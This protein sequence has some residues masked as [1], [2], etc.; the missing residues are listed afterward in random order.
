MAIVVLRDL[1]YAPSVEKPPIRQYTLF[2]KTPVHFY[3]SLIF[4]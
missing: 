3:K 2:D 1:V 4:S